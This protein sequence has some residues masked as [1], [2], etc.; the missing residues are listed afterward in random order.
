M[1][2]AKKRKQMREALNKSYSDQQLAII[3]WTLEGCPTGMIDEILEYKAKEIIGACD[4]AFAY[5]PKF[6]L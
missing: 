6:Y 3:L 4:D 1:K 5:T 2:D